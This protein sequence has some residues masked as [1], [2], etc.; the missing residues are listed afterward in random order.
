MAGSSARRLMMTAFGWNDSGGG[1]TVPRLVAKELARRGWEVTVFHAAVATIPGAAPYQIV[2]SEDDG[3]NLIGIHN[4][5]H[6][7]FD[8][9]HPQRELDDPPI[10]AAFSDALDRVQPQVI[11]FHNLHNLGAALLDQGLTR[12]LPAYF[13][14]HNY[15]LIC[16]RAYLLRGDGSIC[17][18]PGD[19]RGCAQ[20]VGSHDASGH[21]Q[22]LTQIRATAERSLRSIL[23]VSDSVRQTLLA[24]GYPPE[25]IDVVRQAM[26][27]EADIWE[28]VGR[29][30]APGRRG[31]ETL[32]VAFLG[33]AYPHKGPQLLVQ[34]AQETQAEIRVRILGEVPPPFAASLKSLDRRGVVDV[35][36]AFAPDQIGELLREVDAVALPSMWWDCAPLAAAECLAA[37][38]P[39][40]VPRLGGL[41]EA[42]RDDV[43]GLTF[44]PLDAGD[45]ARQLDRLALEPGL[46]ERLQGAIDPP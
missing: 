31:K 15:W 4:R 35:A 3:V 28:R 41:P 23:A 16:P 34:A 30:R 18:G 44:K 26:P 32:T 29:E 37:G 6:G 7:L 46:L 38:T 2:R 17:S 45:L 10:T 9:G 12:G 36:G 22:R 25:L 43:D 24:A 19:G 1:T 39:L 27:H 13:S 21:K 11:H 42:I 33:S 40:L 5:P 8:Y 20:C 14:T